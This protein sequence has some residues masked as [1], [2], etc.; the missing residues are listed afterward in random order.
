MRNHEDV[1]RFWFVDHG[2]DDW[3][4][5]N[6]EF[7]DSIAA[8]FG[9]THGAV[10]RGE[11][12]TW[13]TNAYGRLAEIIVLDQF[14][15]QLFRGRAQ[16]FA[17]DKMALVLAQE[18]V[19][20]DLDTSLS[21]DERMFAYLPYMHSESLVVHDEAMRLYAGLGN[22]DALGFEQKHREV[23]ARFGRFPK[24]NQALGRQSTQEE[25][26]YIAEAGDRAF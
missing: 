21:A 19:L 12:W 9:E 24:R 16:A 22:E 2:Q 6:P 25:L 20:L 10:A 3:F 1:Y 23:I 8:V 4:A 13:R 18:L 11:A 15:R 7:D 17:Q 26:A 5:G 14:S